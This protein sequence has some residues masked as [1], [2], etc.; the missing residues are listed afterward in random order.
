MS[1]ICL[2]SSLPGSTPRCP[3]IYDKF[4]ADD[5]TPIPLEFTSPYTTPDSHCR[6]LFK[7]K[8]QMSETSEEEV[9]VKV[10]MDDYGSVAHRLAAENGFAPKL[11]GVAELAGAPRAYVMEFLSQDKGWTSL[12]NAYSRLNNPPR[13]GQLET[14][15]QRLILFLRTNGLVHGDLRPPNLLFRIQ[16]DDIELRVVDWDWSGRYPD[17]RYPMHRNPEANFLGE[18][19]DPIP[20]DHDEITLTK[21]IKA[22]KV[23]PIL[24]DVRLD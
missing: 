13:W 20:M 3:R 23:S 14:A 21:Y 22:L 7:A 6:L 24:G 16:E 5:G 10:V 12:R 15:A 19:G 1:L 8:A 18:A 17:A 2:C 9:L 4:H 11:Y